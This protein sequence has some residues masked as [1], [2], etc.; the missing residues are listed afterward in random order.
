MPRL[1]SKRLQKE[2][3]TGRRMALVEAEVG[4]FDERTSFVCGMTAENG[5]RGGGGGGG[6]PAGSRAPRTR[7]LHM[8]KEKG[9]QDLGKDVAPSR[10]R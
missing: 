3:G 2:H 10:T 9:R 1:A 5:P 6:M 7:R 8:L 4:H